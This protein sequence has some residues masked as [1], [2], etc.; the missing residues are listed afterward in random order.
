[1]ALIGVLGWWQGAVETSRSSY[2]TFYG[3]HSLAL[4]GWEQSLLVDGD[5]D[6]RLGSE[7]WMGEIS[8]FFSSLGKSWVILH[9]GWLQEFGSNHGCRGRALL[10]GTGRG[11]LPLRITVAILQ[12]GTISRFDASLQARVFVDMQVHCS[13]KSE[14]NKSRR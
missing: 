13:I 12:I 14:E 8:L 10:L 7:G 3:F 11:M 1:M 6:G 4:E 9:L 5:D 2:R